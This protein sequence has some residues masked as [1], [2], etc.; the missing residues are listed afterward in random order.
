[1]II[2][3][4]DNRRRGAEFQCRMI[5]VGGGDI[6]DLEKFGHELRTIFG[7][8]EKLLVFGHLIH[9]ML[10]ESNDIEK[11]KTEPPVTRPSIFQAQQLPLLQP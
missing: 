4:S 2:Q 7:D 5:N 3:A 8:V 11:D 10:S 1:M 9:G 6:D